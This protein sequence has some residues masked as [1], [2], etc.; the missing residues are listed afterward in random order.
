MK[1]NLSIKSAIG[2]SGLGLVMLFTSLSYSQDDKSRNTRRL[3]FEG[4]LIEGQMGTIKALIVTSEKRPD[5]KPMAL[6]LGQV[7]DDIQ[8]L[9]DYSVNE[10]KYEKPFPVELDNQ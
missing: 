9:E 6:Q 7:S 8:N 4:S 10:D 2:F 3:K 5:F 1:K